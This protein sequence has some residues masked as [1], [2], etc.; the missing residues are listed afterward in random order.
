MK[1][2]E[3]ASRSSSVTQLPSATNVD[4]FDAARN[5]R[6]VP[7][8]KEKEVDKFFLHFEKVAV[9]LKWP[10]DG[11]TLMLQSVFIGKAREIYAALAVDQSAD[12]DIV[13]EAILKG[14]ELVP[15]AYR[16]NFRYMK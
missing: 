8:F 14:Y 5:I 13:K 10:K 16:Q 7:K 3:L 15:E 2:L 11:W 4:S 6:L 1:E 9:S 12:Y